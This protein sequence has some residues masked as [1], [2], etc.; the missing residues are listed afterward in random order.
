MYQRVVVVEDTL[1]PVITLDYNNIPIH[2][3][4]SS[5][6]GHND[7]AN[8]AGDPKHNPYLTAGKGR[9]TLMSRKF[10]QLMAEQTSSV[11]GWVIGA[12]ASAVAGVA[13]LGLSRRSPVVTSVPV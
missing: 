7:V 9:V 4:D 3:G 2:T 11:N 6:R 12:V 10:K 13:L 1:K 8:L 5:D